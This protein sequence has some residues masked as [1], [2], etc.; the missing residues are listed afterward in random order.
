MET[1]LAVLLYIGAISTNVEYT[2]SEI[3]SIESQNQGAVTQVES[4]PYQLDQADDIWDTSSMIQSGPGKVII[5]ED[6]QF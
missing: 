1:L 5:T 4:D 2:E 3:L 6:P